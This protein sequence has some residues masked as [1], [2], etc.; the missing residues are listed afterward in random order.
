MEL[1]NPKQLWTEI[2]T[3]VRGYWGTCVPVTA[4]TEP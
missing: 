2:D 4:L 3:S 1:L